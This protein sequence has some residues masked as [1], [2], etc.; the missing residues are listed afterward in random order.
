V[1]VAGALSSAAW[2][3]EWA[4]TGG[5]DPEPDIDAIANGLVALVDGIGAEDAASDDDE[6]DA[7][8]TVAAAP[9]LLED[10]T[11]EIAAI[12]VEAVPEPLAANAPEPE[13]ESEPEQEPVAESESVPEA[14]IV[15][16]EEPQ[17][18]LTL[19]RFEI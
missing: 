18:E 10:A 16:V 7:D 14:E 13:P 5:G 4:Y 1:L 2:I 6:F 15:P 8:A 11:A 3:V 9:L 12:E 19:P 17:G